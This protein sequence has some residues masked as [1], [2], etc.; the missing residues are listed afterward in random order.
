M[1]WVVFQSKK[2]SAQG[3]GQYVSGGTD[4]RST[5]D[6]A[7]AKASRRELCL[8]VAAAAVSSEMVHFLSGDGHAQADVLTCKQVVFML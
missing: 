3:H 5:P 8:H 4:Q 7:Q 2:D 1:V 6:A